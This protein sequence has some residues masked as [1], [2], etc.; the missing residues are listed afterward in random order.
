MIL[1]FQ[2][3]EDFYTFID[4][5]IRQF[6][7]DNGGVRLTRSMI[8]KECGF[9]NSFLHGAKRNNSDV[10]ISYLLTVCQLLGYELIFK[11]K[12]GCVTRAR[13]SISR[14]SLFETFLMMCRSTSDL[15]L[16]V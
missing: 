14:N 9:S 12:S 8:N 5:A 11:K 2:E 1:R 3:P 10:G 4:I 16:L 15:S 6:R 13:D 7:K